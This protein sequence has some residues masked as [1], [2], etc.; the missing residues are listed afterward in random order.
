MQTFFC[1][2][3]YAAY[4]EWVNE[5]CKSAGVEILAY[6][7]MPNHVHFIV[8]PSHPDA[9]RFALAGAHRRYTSLINKRQRWQGHLWQERF[10]SFPMDDE[11]LIAAVRYVELNPVRARLVA[12]PDGWEW[13]SAPAHIQGRTDGLV[14]AL[15]PP[16]LDRIG[17]W[18][19]YLD[20][21]AHSETCSQIRSHSQSGRPLGSDRFV[22]RLEGLTGRALKPRARGRPAHEQMDPE[23]GNCL[24]C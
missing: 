10:H 19:K 14:S 8:V 21:G 16:P 5:G 2:S 22:A 6:C 11:H 20:A 23:N 3:D 9:L 12:T 24:I 4:R 18:A 1:E 7:L 17:P 13:S 15:L